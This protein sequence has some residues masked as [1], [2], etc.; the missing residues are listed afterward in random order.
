M[1]YALSAV[2]FGSLRFYLYRPNENMALLRVQTGSESK[3]ANVL[4]RSL[5]FRISTT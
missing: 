3:R 2:Y 4:A 1:P 5:R